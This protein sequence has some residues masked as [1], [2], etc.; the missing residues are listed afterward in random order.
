MKPFSFPK[1]N[2]SPIG[3]YSVS[4][5]TEELQ[6]SNIQFCFNHV[7]FSVEVESASNDYLRLWYADVW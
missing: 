5:K 3:L 7:G 1:Y 4:L 6:I 2:G